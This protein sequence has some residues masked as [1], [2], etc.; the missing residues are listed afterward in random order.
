MTRLIRAFAIATLMTV[1][2][3]SAALA[4]SEWFFNPDNGDVV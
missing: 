3:T 2:L 1:T 4:A